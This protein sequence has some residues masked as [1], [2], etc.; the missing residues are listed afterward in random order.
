MGL[1][2]KELRKARDLSQE[3][4]AYLSGVSFKTIAR[5]EREDRASATTLNKVATALQVNVGDL[6]TNGDAA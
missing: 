1:R 4:L 5:M 6:F 2:I 3:R